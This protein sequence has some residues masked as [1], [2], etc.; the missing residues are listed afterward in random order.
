MSTPS[1]QFSSAGRRLRDSQVRRAANGSELLLVYFTYAQ[2]V[3]DLS[4]LLVGFAPDAFSA[5]GVLERFSNSLFNAAEWSSS[6]TAPLPKSRETN[7]LLLLRT[8]GNAFHEEDQTDS[9]WLG[10][11]S[12]PSNLW[13]HVFIVYYTCRFWKRLLRHLTTF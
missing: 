4:R 8:F 11:V 1:S 12:G 2:K 6:W 5:P 9:A 7:I 10:R 13:S 3:I